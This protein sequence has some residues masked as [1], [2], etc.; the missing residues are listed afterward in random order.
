MKEI[1]RDI[2]LNRLISRKGNGLIKIITGIRRCGKSYLL[3]P[4][5][6][7][8]LLADGVPADHIIKI[9]LDRMSNR[10]YHHDPTGFDQYIHS[11]IQDEQTY[12]ILLDE[13]QLVEDFEYVL[14]G[15]LYEKNIDLYVTGSNSRFLSSDVITEFRG[16]GDQIYIRPLSFSEFYKASQLDKYDSWNE[17]LTYGGM[18][19]VLSYKTETEKASYLQNLFTQTYFTDIIERYQ[20]QK[21]DILDALVS[22]LASSVGS[23]TNTQKLYDT[24]KSNGVKELSINTINAYL[25][26]LEDAFIV[27]KALRYDIKGKKYINTPHKYYYTDVGLRNARLNFRQ[28]EASHI[29]E[30]IIYNELLLRGLNVDVGIV[31]LR[32]KGRRIQTEVDFVCNTGSNRYYIQ[33]SL[34]LDTPEKLTQ[35]TRS[36]KNISDNF[37]K[38]IVVKDH[39]KPWRTEDGISVIGVLDFLLNPD[40]L[41][42]C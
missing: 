21:T 37:K 1:N 13:I 33:S 36:L 17:Y 40:S 11:L 31:E 5:F 34:N 3:D 35:E 24:F 23:L 14:N 4:L 15:L 16:R 6:K 7:N 41:V 8:H 19:L 27:H 9:E 26:Y 28:Q 42:L 18:P 39:I 25:S 30:N 22:I 2:H 38:I 10:K 12:Y 32:N 29:M 20:I